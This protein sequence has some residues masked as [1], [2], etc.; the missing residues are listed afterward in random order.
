MFVFDIIACLLQTGHGLLNQ[1][2]VVQFFFFVFITSKAEIIL[3][4]RDNNLKKNTHR[5][6]ETE[7]TLKAQFLKLEYK[8]YK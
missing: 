2:H 6:K 8:V 4:F 5:K 3:N 1:R 7:I